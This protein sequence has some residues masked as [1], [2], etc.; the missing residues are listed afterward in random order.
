M[1]LADL[2]VW[3]HMQQQYQQP[4]GNA[5]PLVQ[6]LLGDVGSTRSGRA[7]KSEIVREKILQALL[8]PA[9]NV[10]DVVN[11]TPDPLHQ[12]ENDADSTTRIHWLLQKYDP[13]TKEFFCSLSA[14]P[15]TLIG[16]I[17][18]R[19]LFVRSGWAK[20]PKSTIEKNVRGDHK[21]MISG[22]HRNNLQ[23]PGVTPWTQ[24]HAEALKDF[25]YPGGPADRL[26]KLGCAFVRRHFPQTAQRFDTCARL[27][28]EKHGI[29]SD[30]DLFFNFCL[31]YPSDEAPRVY[32]LPHVDWKNVAF[33]VC[34][35]FVHGRFHRKER[36]WLVLW[37]AGV[38]IQV[39]PG[40]FVA[41]PSSLFMHFNSDRSLIVTTPDGEL[42]TL[43]TTEYS[44]GRDGRR[45]SVWFTQASVVQTAELGYTTVEMAKEAGNS[46]KCDK[47][48][49]LASG[50]FPSI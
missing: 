35:V 28:E 39:P 27:L 4:N 16:N 46:G 9:V 42:P 41:Y 44:D 18:R 6:M 17:D 14:Q 33:G 50:N 7:Y 3:R 15:P 32:C 37:E 21:F 36:A 22:Y 47:D 43:E 5:D 10:P 45:S 40:G 19:N 29:R 49:M 1:D 2:A 48:K 11:T 24:Q 25:F 23:E 8:A 26:T 12:R 31:N 38:I 34:L 30:Y 20:I 13:S